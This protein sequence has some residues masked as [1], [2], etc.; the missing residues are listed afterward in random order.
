MTYCNFLFI[1]FIF[2]FIQQMLVLKV[3]YELYNLL[4]YHGYQYSK[5]NIILSGE[6]T[7]MM[8]MII[9]VYQRFKQWLH[10]SLLCLS[11]F[12]DES[13]VCPPPPFSN[14]MLRAWF[15]LYLTG[16][17]IESYIKTVLMRE[18]TYELYF[19]KREETVCLKHPEVFTSDRTNALLILEKSN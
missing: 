7:M 13:A 18:D 1:I 9:I 19:I 17:F 11:T 10:S 2:T 3:F 15:I 6:M 16:G 12:L 4:C 5:W 14:T 8:L